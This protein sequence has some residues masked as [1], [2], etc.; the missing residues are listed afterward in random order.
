MDTQ[1]YDPSDNV[2]DAHKTHTRAMLSTSYDAKSSDPDK[3]TMVGS[4][5]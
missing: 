3:V 2:A 4:L 5:V 1:L